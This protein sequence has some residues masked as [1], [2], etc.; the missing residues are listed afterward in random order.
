[1]EINIKW[2][3]LFDQMP[4]RLMLLLLDIPYAVQRKKGKKKNFNVCHVKGH[5]DVAPLA[6]DITINF[7]VF[8]VKGHLDITLMI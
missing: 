1:M 3:A 4:I 5:L 6:H 8:H 2:G 7:N